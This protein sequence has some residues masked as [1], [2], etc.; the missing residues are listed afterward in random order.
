MYGG[1]IWEN[2]F[3]HRPKR[4]GTWGLV[5]H[6]TKKSD[7]WVKAER[8]AISRLPQSA[9]RASVSKSLQQKIPYHFLNGVAPGILSEMYDF[10]R[11]SPQLIFGACFATRHP[12]APNPNNDHQHPFLTFPHPQAFLRGTTSNFGA[13]R[14]R[15]VGSEGW[16]LLFSRMQNT[17]M[18][19]LLLFGS[20]RTQASV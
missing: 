9:Q 3:E 1:L 2:G 19:R 13:P 6:V 18:E 4:V 8:A 11:L 20:P 10:F 15:T 17:M 14:L 5:I 16:I 12:P 7:D